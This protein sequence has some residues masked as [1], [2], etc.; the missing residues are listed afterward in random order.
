MTG[1]ILGDMSQYLFLRRQTSVTRSEVTTLSN[2]LAS[3]TASDLA[4][5]LA[6]QT[7]IVAAIQTSLSRLSAFDQ[8]IARAT[9]RADAMQAA[10]DKVD[11]AARS[12]ANDLLQA[13]GAG[14]AALDTATAIGR[15]AFDD[16][17]NALNTRIG[18]RSLFAGTA[19]DRDALLAPE[20]LLAAARLAIA[21]ATAPADIAAALDRWL[22]DPAGFTATAFLGSSDTTAIAVAE[23]IAVTLPVTAADP[24]L[25]GTFKGLILAALLS[26]SSFAGDRAARAELA[27]LAGSALIQSGDDRTAAAARLGVAQERIAT[28]E[29]RNSAEATA[30]GIARSDLV[31][32]DGYETA[33]RLAEAQTRLETIYTLTAR[34]SDLS[35]ANYLR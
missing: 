15:A 9:S 29:A 5:H 19:T 27:T 22:A 31:A 23:D 21:P 17:V 2:D 20:A 26:D 7:G 16:A 28:A 32:I 8:T 12:A 33:S 10:L 1:P 4:R 3:G 11:T 25:R 34:L 24:D 35:L 13:A 14:G 6:G 30:L 18:D